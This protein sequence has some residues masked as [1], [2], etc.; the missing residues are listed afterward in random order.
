MVREIVG[1]GPDVG[2]FGAAA[3]RA[4]REWIAAHREQ[5]QSVKPTGVGVAFTERAC[6]NMA[7]DADW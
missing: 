3:A 1:N 4:W 2:R 6:Q 5:L 7:V